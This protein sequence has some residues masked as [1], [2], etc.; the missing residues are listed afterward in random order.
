MDE[1]RVFEGSLLRKGEL[2]DAE[3]TFPFAIERDGDGQMQVVLEPGERK[4]ALAPMHFAA[5]RMNL[6]A[7]ET[8]S[9]AE[10]RAVGG[11][12]CTRSSPRGG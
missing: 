5:H 11:P 10:F 4:L 7:G 3:A 12:N 2:H 8:R 1:T 9:V 6:D